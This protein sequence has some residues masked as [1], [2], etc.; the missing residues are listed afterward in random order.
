MIAKVLLIAFLLASC[1]YSDDLMAEYP[2][3][4]QQNN[5]QS[6]DE[7][8][9]EISVQSSHTY[10]NDKPKVESSRQSKPKKS[11][12]IIAEPE[13]IEVENSSTSENNSNT[14]IVQP[15]ETLYSISRKYGVDINQFA[16]ANGIDSSYQIKIGQKL[17]IPSVQAEAAKSPINAPAKASPQKYTLQKYIVEPK[18]TIYSI[19]RKY[20]IHPKSIQQA[21]NINDTHVLIIGSTILLPL[22]AAP[23]VNPVATPVVTPLP[24][25]A[26]SVAPQ[27]PEDV[28]PIPAAVPIPSVDKKALKNEKYKYPV[29]SAVVSTFGKKN[30]GVHNDGLLF[31]V[32]SNMPVSASKSGVVIYA[33]Y[34]KNYNNLIIV[35]HEDDMVSVYGNLDKILVQKGEQVSGSQKIAM[36]NPSISKTFYFAIRGN[37]NGQK[38]VDPMRFLS[39]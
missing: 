24:S 33:S 37:N 38:P 8:S 14:Y 6:G 17:T 5:G 23:V 36:L 11:T 30:K 26:Q 34:L 10:R 16:L 27:M 31:A 18:D 20:Q 29:S 21:N 25:V 28:K 3:E 35:R 4:N 2:T 32:S 39:K 1:S 9:D 7:K 19:A 22:Q 13:A 15:K 12:P